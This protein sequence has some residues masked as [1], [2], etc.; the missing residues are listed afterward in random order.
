MRPGPQGHVSL[1]PPR[2]PSS[3]PGAAAALSPEHERAGPGSHRLQ[4]QEPAEPA[5]PQRPQPGRRRHLGAA[6]SAAGASASAGVTETAPDPRE[7]GA[8]PRPGTAGTNSQPGMSSA[9]LEQRCFSLFTA[10]LRRQPG[11]T[12]VPHRWS[13]IAETT[14]NKTISPF[15]GTAAKRHIG[16]RA[17][18]DS[19]SDQ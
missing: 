2:P 1:R 4:P 13:G 9:I 14:L 15:S 5:P 11:G 19:P 12:A 7:R 3:L 10:V 16:P 17:V 8:A 18:I 6:A